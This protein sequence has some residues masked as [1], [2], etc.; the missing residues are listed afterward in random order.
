MSYDRK[1]RAI[2]LKHVETGK[3]QEE[4]RNMFG[5]GKNT[6]TEWKKLRSETNNLKNRPLKR[7]FR[8]I[9]PDKLRKDIEERP[10]EFNS[11]RA[12]RFGCS[13]DG[14]RRAL[15]RNK[16]TRKKRV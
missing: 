9:D 3:S 4:V 14:M 2:V 16:L 12:K 5:L 11:E 10:D 1:F 7:R 13:E 15:K 6:I 8:K